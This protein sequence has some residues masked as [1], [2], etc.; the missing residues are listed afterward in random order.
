MDDPIWIEP[1]LV[2]AIHTSQLATHGGADG[3]RDPGLLAS[4]LARPRHR[5]AYE[6]PTPD[7]PAL[8]ASYAFGIAKNHAFV[9]GNKRTAF[10]VCAL[11]LERNGYQLTVDADERYRAMLAL[12]AGEWDEPTFADW[13]AK[14]TRR[15]G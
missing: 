15:V 9:D 4:A 13:L 14:S 2:T 1:E 10:V 6:D 3:V 8:A 12:A 11:F 7:V 5:F